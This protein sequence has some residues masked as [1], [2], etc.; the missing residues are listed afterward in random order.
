LE[1]LK[2]KL[3]VFQKRTKDPWILKWKYE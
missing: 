2:Q 3:K 1:E